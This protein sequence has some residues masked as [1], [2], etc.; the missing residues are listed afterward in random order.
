MLMEMDR[1]CPMKTSPVNNKNSTT[2]DPRRQ[3]EEREAKNI[4]EK[5]S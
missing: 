3:E 5:N 1:T 4:M 2:L